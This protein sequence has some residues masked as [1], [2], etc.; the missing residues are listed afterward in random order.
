MINKKELGINVLFSVLYTIMMV[1]NYFLCDLISQI[2]LLVFTYLLFLVYCKKKLKSLNLMLS[3]PAFIYASVFIPYVLFAI[4]V[5]IVN[6]YQPVIHYYKINT[7]TMT[8]TTTFYIYVYLI[9]LILL[10]I[11][12][13]IKSLNIKDGISVKFSKLKSFFNKINI[14]DVIIV[15]FSIYNLYKV[16]SFGNF[17]SLTTLQK[18]EITNSEVSHYVNLIVMIYSLLLTC[19]YINNNYE[20]K[21]LMIFRI[22]FTILYWIIYIT[23]ER[24]I[25]VTF[26]L[27]FIILY[28]ARLVKIKLKN[29]LIFILSVIA[30]LLSASIR[31]NVTL[32]NHKT[33]DVVFM[34]LGEFYLTY[35]ISNY[36]V[37]QINNID[38]EYGKTYV[39]SSFYSLFPSFLVSNKPEG[40]ANKFEKDHNLNVGFSFNPVSE[41][42]I[43][44]GK[45]AIISVPFLIFLIII[46]SN[47]IYKFN[48]L[49]P[50][51][52]SMFSIDFYRGQF[53]NFFF[54]SIYCFVILFLIFNINHTSK[55]R[56]KEVQ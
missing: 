46:I 23:C 38:Y 11:S 50:I 4:V 40:L 42:I 32:N 31:G 27:G 10:T 35:S 53:S 1:I 47:K 16:L 45:Y 6:H 43:N 33:E 9:T 5:F 21:K 18:R 2:V 39:V 55:Y 28:A 15:F 56:K 14:L 12:N 36:Y 19:Y 49:M 52:I 26:L 13:Q 48:V 8:N 41:G 22:I 34:S 37:E 54:D 3:S 24:R 17:L 25:I 29:V 51:I 7:E 44:F 20:K 30:L